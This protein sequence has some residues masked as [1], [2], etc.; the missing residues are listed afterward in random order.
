[1][2]ITTT[3]QR[4]KNDGKSNF[5]TKIDNRLIKSKLL[6]SDEKFIMIY[7]LS[8]DDSYN[9]IREVIQKKVGMGRNRF[10]SA[11][12]NLQNLSFIIDKGQA[13]KGRFGKKKFIVNEYPLVAPE[14]D[15]SNSSF[16]N[17]E[18][19][20][21][22][23]TITSAPFPHDGIPTNGISSNT[24]AAYAQPMV[25]KL[26]ANNNQG[27]QDQGNQD[28]GNQDQGNQDQGNQDQFSQEDTDDFDVNI[29]SLVH[30]IVNPTMEMSSE[31]SIALEN[32]L[33]RETKYQMQE[34]ISD[35]FVFGWHTYDREPKFDSKQSQD[36]LLNYIFSDII[37]IPSIFKYI[38]FLNERYFKQNVENWRFNEKDIEEIATTTQNSNLNYQTWEEVF[39][40]LNQIAERAYQ[41]GTDKVT[42]SYLTKQLNVRYHFEECY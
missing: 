4:S 11:W 29:K 27:N 36:Y 5:Y 41:C 15:I 21:T 2:G 24:E 9:L 6:S 35:A 10:T 1:M 3:Y 14:E 42:V 25:G 23:N 19:S 13:N 37:W 7:I 32:E 18:Q 8:Q 28:Q 22:Q 20:K 40:I 39:K 33:F 17:E 26:P 30:K 34:L 31:T 12:N 38:L 16:E